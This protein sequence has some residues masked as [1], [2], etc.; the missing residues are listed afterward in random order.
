MKPDALKGGFGSA[1]PVRHGLSLSHAG[2]GSA[3]NDTSFD[4]AAAAPLSVAAGV[5]CLPCVTLKRRY[6]LVRRLVRRICGGSSHWRA[7]FCGW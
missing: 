7:L 1:C 5:V 4:G 2:N 6:S 3:R